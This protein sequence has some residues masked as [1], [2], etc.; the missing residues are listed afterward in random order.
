MAFRQTNFGPVLELIRRDFEQ[1]VR[2]AQGLED[3]S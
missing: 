3:A 1:V 2:V